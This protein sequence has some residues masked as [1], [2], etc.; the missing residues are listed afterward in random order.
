MKALAQISHSIMLKVNAEL[1]VEK[2]KKVL[3]TSMTFTSKICACRSLK[4][5]VIQINECLP[6]FLGFNGAGILIKNKEE[7]ELYSIPI[8]EEDKS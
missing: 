6:Q 3:L 7:K 1:E 2:L 8:Y 5:L 4:E